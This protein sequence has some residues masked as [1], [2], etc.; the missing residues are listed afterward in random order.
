MSVYRNSFMGEL[1]IDNLLAGGG[2]GGGGGERVQSLLLFWKT[3]GR[4]N[5][6]SSCAF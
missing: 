1:A 3:I 2:G 5:Y 4:I 6:T